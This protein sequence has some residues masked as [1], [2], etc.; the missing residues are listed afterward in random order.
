MNQRRPIELI[1]LLPA[2]WASS[3]AQESKEFRAGEYITESH[4][5]NCPHLCQPNSTAG[6]SQEP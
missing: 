2:Q 5:S 3:G 4:Y 1:A 6:E